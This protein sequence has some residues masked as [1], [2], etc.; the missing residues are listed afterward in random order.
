MMDGRIE[1]SRTYSGWICSGVLERELFMPVCQIES[2][3]N[4]TA[5]EQEALRAEETRANLASCR[6]QEIG[7]AATAV[8]L[9]AAC[10][11]LYG[12]GLL[13]AEPLGVAV[14]LSVPI[15][16]PVGVI[17]GGFA[18]SIF[19]KTIVSVKLMAVVLSLIASLT[20]VGW[21]LCIGLNGSAAM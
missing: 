17:T 14:F 10:W 19:D 13:D 11:G 6:A 20:I 15:A 3:S 7:M 2:T 21:G 8:G 18:H 16:I 5:K 12:L 4:L 1:L 9:W